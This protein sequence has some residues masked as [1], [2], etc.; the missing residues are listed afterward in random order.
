VQ[1]GIGALL[2]PTAAR[3]ASSVPDAEEGVLSITGVS[4]SDGEVAITWDDDP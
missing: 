4:A 3:A 2:L 1:F